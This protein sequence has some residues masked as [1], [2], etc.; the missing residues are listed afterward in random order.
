MTIPSWTKV[1]AKVVCIYHTKHSNLL[2]VNKVYT[3]SRVGVGS[4]EDGRKY[5]GVGLREIDLRFNAEV[6]PVPLQWVR[7]VQTKTQE[8]DVAIFAP[9]LET[10]KESA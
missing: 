10:E 1:G 7:P 6:P 8:Q 2:T 3:I 4:V 5:L 9:L